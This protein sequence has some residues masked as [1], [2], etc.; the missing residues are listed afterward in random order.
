M[1]TWYCIA[2]LRAE[3]WILALRNWQWDLHPLYLKRFATE[4]LPSRALTTSR[5]EHRFNWFN[6]N[7]LE[8]LDL[9]SFVRWS[10]LTVLSP[11]TVAICEY[12]DLKNSETDGV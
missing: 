1:L 7:R 12:H 3:F 5:Y 2:I 10:S 11:A 4:E 8:C 9:E 6:C